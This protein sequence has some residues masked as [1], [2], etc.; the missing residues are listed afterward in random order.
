MS[1]KYLEILKNPRWQKKRKEILY[2]DGYRC[3][4]CGSKHKLNVHHIFYIKGRL[5]WEYP[6]YALITLCR[7][8]HLKWHDEHDIIKKPDNDKTIGFG[9]DRDKKKFKKP[10]HN[11]RP[12][13]KS[14]KKR[15]VIANERSL[16]A[17]QPGNRHRKK[18][19]GVWIIIEK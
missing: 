8:C 9:D 4:K 12:K 15:L 18:V 2:R 10:F 3:A 14:M 5:P 13:P 19:D 11:R 16:A 6:N 7:S 17:T 1:E